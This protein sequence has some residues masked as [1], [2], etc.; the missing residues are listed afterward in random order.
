LDFAENVLT[1]NVPKAYCLKATLPFPVDSENGNAKF[2][3]QKRQLIVTLPV[4]PEPIPRD[5]SFES[6]LKE[7]NL[8]E[9]KSLVEDIPQETIVEPKVPE[10]KTEESIEIQNASEAQK[11]SYE[12]FITETKEQLS[13]E[14][15]L[16]EQ[17]KIAEKAT[18]IILNTEYLFSL[19]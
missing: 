14:S 1:L 3:K 15:T 9:E 11:D 19:D 13:N 5:E 2:D 17:P 16:V 6:E 10:T 4:V 18:P 12:E 7:E 8:L